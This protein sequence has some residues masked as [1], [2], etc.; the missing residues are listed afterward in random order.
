MDCSRLLLSFPLGYR[1]GLGSMSARYKAETKACKM[2]QER[3]APMLVGSRLG[4]GLQA[5]SMQ[6]PI[7]LFYT[8]TRAKP[9]NKLPL[10]PNLCPKHIQDLVM[11]HQ[12]IEVLQ[13][14]NLPEELKEL[15][16]K[17]LL[18][19]MQAHQEDNQNEQEN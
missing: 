19:A 17:G 15:A 7:H 18:M 5:H 12:L 16:E 8:P 1:S 3:Q 9:M 11:V 13:N 6:R 14:P 2:L 10:T 4:C